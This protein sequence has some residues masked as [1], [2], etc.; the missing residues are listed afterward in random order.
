MQ[1]CQ[2]ARELAVHGVPWV[3]VEKD[4]GLDARDNDVVAN[5]AFSAG[6]GAI[7]VKDL[8]ARNGDGTRPM[9]C[10]ADR[11]MYLGWEWSMAAVVD[12]EAENRHPVADRWTRKLVPGRLLPLDLYLLRVGRRV[13]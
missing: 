5:A 1:R 2:A 10:Q 3:A 8:V 9:H 6:L 12:M 4:V 13:E 11:R 7:E